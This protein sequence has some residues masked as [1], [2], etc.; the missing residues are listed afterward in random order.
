[1]PAVRP[2]SIRE[3]EGASASRWTDT[4]ER[5][6]PDCSLGVSAP[7]QAEE[8]VPAPNRGFE[9]ALPS[10]LPATLLA[11][12][13]ARLRAG[14]CSRKGVATVC[15]A[16][17]ETARRSRD[18]MAVRLFQ[19][20]LS[21]IQAKAIHLRIRSGRSHRRSL[22]ASQQYGRM[23]D[24]AMANLERRHCTLGIAHPPLLVRGR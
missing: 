7:G 1:M 22:N 21:E 4:R 18:C 24:L 19:L 20:K 3:R 23:A 13:V 2:E 5:G 8:Q 12:G 6:S 11:Q 10:R 15:V 9:R 14:D 17:S 16:D